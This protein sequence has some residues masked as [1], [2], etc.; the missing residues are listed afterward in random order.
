MLYIDIETGRVHERDPKPDFYNCVNKLKYSIEFKMGKDWMEQ[1]DLV[2]PSIYFMIY[3]NYAYYRA[4]NYGK[5]IV[6][7]NNIF[8]ITCAAFDANSCWKIRYVFRD[9]KW[10]F[11][12]S[13]GLK[14]LN[15]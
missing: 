8:I 14:G 7:D 1:Q 6:P 13:W 15:R 12:A 10:C 5:S 9:V 2:L 3:Y 11:D 4:E